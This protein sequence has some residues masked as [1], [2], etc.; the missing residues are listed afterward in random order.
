MA[1]YSSRPLWQKL[2]LKAG[3][4]AVC[5][6]SPPDYRQM[7]GELPPRIT[8]S[9]TLP[10]VAD[11]IHLFTVSLV[12]LEAVLPQLKAT[13]AKDGMLW[14]SWP[15]KAAKI[16]TDLDGNVV[17]ELGLTAGLVDVK[18]AAVDEVWSGLKFV[19]R[20]LDR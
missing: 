7:L 18:V 4:T 11:F 3:Q 15:K 5:L 13:L 16:A 10:P 2:G 8:F 12:E 6:N 19:Y 20:V 9:D 14:I 1:G 17:R